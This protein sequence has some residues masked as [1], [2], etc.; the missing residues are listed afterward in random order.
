[1]TCAPGGE[2][3]LALLGGGA[4]DVVVLDLAMPGLD[5]LQVLSRLR[6]LG[7]DVPVIM[8]TGHGTPSAGLDAM[9]LG[10]VD[11]LLKPVSPDRLALAIET[12]AR[13]SAESR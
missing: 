10:A 7:R 6:E 5:G 9:D 11:F 3:G 2:A 12:A 8:L 13:P 4:F 1:M